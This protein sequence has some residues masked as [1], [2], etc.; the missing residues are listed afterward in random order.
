MKE[1]ELRGK[2]R[3]GE[4]G[5]KLKKRENQYLEV[6][7]SESETKEGRIAP[8]V[9]THIERNANATISTMVMDH[10]NNDTQREREEW[11]GKRE[12]RKK[13]RNGKRGRRNI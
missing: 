5:D 1:N 13:E 7:L 6:S 9:R 4:K 10:L 11:N 12:K 8:H 2:M 3:R